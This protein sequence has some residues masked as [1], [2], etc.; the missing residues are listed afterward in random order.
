MR[1]GLGR[2]LNHLHEEIDGPQNRVVA[3]GCREE[4]MEPSA[5]TFD[6][7]VVEQ[8]HQKHRARQSQRSGEVGRWDNA[9][10]SMVNLLAGA[11]VIPGP[12]LGQ[13]V[14]GQ[15]V[16]GVHQ[17]DPHKHRECQR[18]HKLAALGIVHNTFGLG[19]HELDQ[20]F[21]RGLKAP[22]NTRGTGA[23]RSP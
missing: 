5:Q 21:D 4:L 12:Q 13:E 23:R 15:Q 3:K 1:D 18:G 6:L 20:N 22:R 17:K 11:L 8:T 7:Q 10:I 14:N 2:K 19:V 16:H 9:Q